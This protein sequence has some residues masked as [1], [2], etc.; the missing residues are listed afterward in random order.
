MKKWCFIAGLAL[1]IALHSATPAQ[2]RQWVIFFENSGAVMALDVDS[3]KGVGDIRNFWVNSE[4][5]VP[6]KID[7]FRQASSSLN[8]AWVN[9][10]TRQ[11]GSSQI[12][13]FDNNGREVLDS[14]DNQQPR[15]WSNVLPETDSE[16]ML[17]AVCSLRSR[18][19]DR[20]LTQ[21]QAAASEEKQAESDRQQASSLIKRW[22][23]AK[24]RIFGSAYDRQLAR[25]VTSGKLS[26]DLLKAEGSID[27]LEANQA[28]YAY[29]VQEIDQVRTVN[30]QGKLLT[31]EAY[32]R[33]SSTLQ[34][35]GKTTQNAGKVERSLV[36][37]EFV[38]GFE[39]AWQLRDYKV[40]D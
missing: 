3:I 14:G 4:Y 9:C 5:I 24:R 2:A 31:V 22:F 13:F 39:G 21:R 35:K 16:A 26:Q 7:Y 33:E 25:Q 19:S 11:T 38:T 29:G 1:A 37:Y 32:V 34:T 17:D 18:D 30:R 15:S 28:Y 20:L 6:K 10:Q 8:R 36:R 23:Q 40:L 12:V 27:W